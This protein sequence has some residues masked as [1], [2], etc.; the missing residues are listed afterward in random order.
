MLQPALIIDEPLLHRGI[1]L[2]GEALTLGLHGRSATDRL[3]LFPKT[4]ALQ[5]QHPGPSASLG[6]CE[7]AALVKL[8]G[9]LLARIARL[10]GTLP[11]LDRLKGMTPCLIRR[12]DAAPIRFSQALWDLIGGSKMLRLARCGGVERTRSEQGERG[13]QSA[14]EVLADGMHKE[15]EMTTDGETGRKR[16]VRTRRRYP[17]A[18]RGVTARRRN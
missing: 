8:G 6:L 9:P 12:T 14:E 4:V 10:P 11:A 7:E 15:A 1:P 3:L 18:E 5:L 13:G 16:G 2:V 17:A